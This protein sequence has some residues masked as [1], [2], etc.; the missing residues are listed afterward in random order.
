MQRYDASTAYNLYCIATIGYTLTTTCF[1]LHQCKIIQ[2]HAICATLKMMGI[3][4][5]V[6][7]DVVFGPKYTGVMDL[8]HLHTL[9]G[10]RRI[11]YIIGHITNN[12]VVAKPMPICIEATQLE[13]RTFEQFFFLPESLHGTSLVSRSWINEIWSFIELFAGIINISNT[14]IPHPQRLHDQAIMSLAVLFSQNKGKRIQINISQIYLKT[15][16]MSDI[17]NFDGTRITQQSYD[18]TF[19]M[20]KPNI[21]WPNQHRP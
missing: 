20:K 13:V 19:V 17:C 14:W 15:I 3:N 18:G 5:N 16:S 21:H 6:S 7:R 8:H 9:Q 11:Q 1:S 4:R 10:M 12:D 2:I